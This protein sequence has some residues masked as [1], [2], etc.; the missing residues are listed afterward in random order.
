M[1][2]PKLDSVDNAALRHW[3][4]V[5]TLEYL[6]ARIPDLLSAGPCWRRNKVR[7]LLERLSGNCGDSAQS[8]VVAQGLRCSG[9]LHVPVLFAVDQNCENTRRHLTK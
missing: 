5:A 7:Q 3:P 1:G 4:S 8:D 2:E 9:Q 6:L